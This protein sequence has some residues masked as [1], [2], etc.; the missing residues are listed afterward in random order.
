MAYCTE[1]NF[2]VS[3]GVWTHNYTKDDLAQTEYGCC[4]KFVCGIECPKVGVVGGRYGCC[5]GQQ[6]SCMPGT[7]TSILST[8]AHYGPGWW[9]VTN[10]GNFLDVRYS[11]VNEISEHTTCR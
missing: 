6:A 8:L 7:A 4:Q 9:Q 3:P 11:D 2:E 1:A 10:K 5:R